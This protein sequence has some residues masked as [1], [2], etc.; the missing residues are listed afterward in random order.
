MSLKSVRAVF[1][2]LDGT[3][4][5]SFQ[6][7]QSGYNSALSQLAGRT[8]SLEEVRKIVGGGLRDSFVELVGEE[9]ADE[10]VTLF[11]TTYR[12]VYRNETFLLPT[13]RETI[14]TLKETGHLL[15]V[16]SNKYGDF[17]RGILESLGLSGFFSFVIG[18]GDG[19][20][21]KPDPAIMNALLKRYNLNTEEAIYLGD[22]PIDIA[23]C[24]ASGTRSCMVATGNY[25]YGQL[26]E[27]QPENLFPTLQAFLDFFNSA[28]PP[29][30]PSPIYSPD[31]A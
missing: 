14:E 13:V 12:E 30:T 15:G 7:I 24:R 5:D 9:K 18:D 17:S 8:L 28:G 2:D 26:S 16:I 1:F 27:H 20:P 4:V 10:A 6:A 23:F 29:Y 25:T 21:L 3:L 22:G 11:R 31:P 19:Y